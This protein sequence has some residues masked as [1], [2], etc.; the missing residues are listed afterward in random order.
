[1]DISSMT[2][3][4][5]ALTKMSY[6]DCEIVDSA[7]EEFKTNIDSFNEKDLSAFLFSVGGFLH[8]D[9]GSIVICKK[10]NFGFLVIF[11]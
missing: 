4:M 5:I 10:Y 6:L 2:L 1:M 3:M 8:K 7:V 9:P 11:R